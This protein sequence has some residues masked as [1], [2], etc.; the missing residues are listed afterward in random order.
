MN[1]KT[2]LVVEIEALKAARAKISNPTNWCQG[3]YAR[4]RTG[5]K[6]FTFSNRATA[7]CL[8]GALDSVCM[9]QHWGSEG[10]A[11]RLRTTSTR[12]GYGTPIEANDNGC[13]ADVISIYDKAIADAEAELQA[14]AS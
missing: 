3:A 1:T 2:D 7:W 11:D 8:Y 9:E 12:L 4:G 14:V 6:V 13:H 5:R 10:P